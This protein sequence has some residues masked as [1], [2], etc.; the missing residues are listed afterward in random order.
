MFEAIVA[1]HMT[2]CSMNNFLAAASSLSRER[3]LKFC[4]E[5]GTPCALIKSF[6]LCSVWQT[7]TDFR[8]KKLLGH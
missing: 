2:L 4:H 6:T 7:R 5:H 1:D 8:G 3:C